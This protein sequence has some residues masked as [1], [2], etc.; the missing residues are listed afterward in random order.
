MEEGPQIKGSN[1]KVSS[2]APHPRGPAQPH[3]QEQMNLCCQPWGYRLLW[4]PK[5]RRSWLETQ[6]KPP[7]PVEV[8]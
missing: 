2:R 8:P 4:F 7:R 3:L 6:P 5:A 1:T